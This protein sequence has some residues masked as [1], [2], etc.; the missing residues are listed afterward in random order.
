MSRSLPRSIAFYSLLVLNAVAFCGLL[1]SYLAGSVSPAEF[2]PLAFAGLAYPLMLLLMLMFTTL[3]AINGKWKLVALHIVIILWRIDLVDGHVQFWRGGED[4]EEAEG[5]RVISYNVHLFSAYAVDDNT[6]ILASMLSN[7]SNEDAHIVSM[8]E[9][10]SKGRKNGP[11]AKKD[12]D[13]FLKDRES[14]IEGYNSKPGGQY[15]KGTALAT[16]TDYPILKRGRLEAKNSSAMRCIYAD[17]L[18]QGDTVRVYNVHLES[19]RIKDE[20]FQ[21]INQALAL[22]EQTDLLHLKPIFR[23]FRKAFI[24]RA[25]LADTLAAHIARC[26]HPVIV[27]GDFND[28]PAAYSYQ[29][30]ASSLKDSFREAGGG[31]GI[32]YARVPLFRIDNILFS[33]HFR[34]TAHKVHHWPHSD[35]Y[36]VSATLVLK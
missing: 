13:Q 34:A 27:C 31:F 8:Q 11:Q 12:F 18:I 36:A 1:A 5:I 16:V 9:Y 21:T 6:D 32:T 33:H 26:T 14:Q 3:W 28:T 2:W 4:A 25:E 17:L 19:I 22:D 15:N 10:F 7:I 35:H 29:R 24:S 30:I 23:K 20:D